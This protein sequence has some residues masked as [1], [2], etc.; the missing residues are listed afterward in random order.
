MPAAVF[1]IVHLV[2]RSRNYLADGLQK[3][4]TML[5]VQA[6]E[7]APIR[8]GIVYVTP[9]DRHLIISSNHVH[10]SRGPKE[11]LHGEASM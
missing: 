7:G 4:T 10:L 3:A 11:G 5:V 6:S 8:P 1:V 2:P 9:A